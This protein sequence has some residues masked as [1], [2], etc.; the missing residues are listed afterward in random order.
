[1]SFPNSTVPDLLLRSPSDK[2]NLTPTL[3][4][5]SLLSHL[6]SVIRVFSQYPHRLPHPIIQGPIPHRMLTHD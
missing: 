6:H 2:D 1:M 5:S 4:L 3:L